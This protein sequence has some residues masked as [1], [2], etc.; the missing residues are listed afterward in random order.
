MIYQ[1][2][3][4]LRPEMNHFACAFDSLAYF[5]ERYQNKPWTEAELQAAWD[6]AIK[7]GLISGD[8]NN[9][10]IMGDTPEELVIQD[11]QKLANYLGCA[12]QYLGKF[13]LDAPQWDG[14]FPIVQWYNRRTKFRH[15]VV[16]D[17][18]PVQWD[19]IEGGS[20]TVKE[21][22]PLDVRLFKPLVAMI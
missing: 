7:S 17:R 21:G 20:I 2:N 1:T 10:G 15:F 13:T 11:W 18:S 14:A 6:G 16:G 12:V 9:N 3:P 8:L 22:V 4:R 19:P 5:R